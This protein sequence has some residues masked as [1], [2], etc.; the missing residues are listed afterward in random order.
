MPDITVRLAGE[1]DAEILRQ[2]N[3]EFNG[4]VDVTAESVRE[5][6]C[7][8]SEIVGIV[9][10]DGRILRGCGTDIEDGD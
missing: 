6:L 7:T 5:S 3:E 8:S 1:K 2:F 4:V 10:V 9:E